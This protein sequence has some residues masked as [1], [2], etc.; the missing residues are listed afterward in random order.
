MD[1]L[2]QV[3]SNTSLT[4]PL[5][6]VTKCLSKPFWTQL[7][8]LHHQAPLPNLE[9]RPPQTGP[10]SEAHACIHFVTVSID[11]SPS[12]PLGILVSLRQHMLPDT[13]I[14]I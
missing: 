5:T 6:A 7:Q 9:A 2:I 11:Y 12:G 8:R 14:K 3:V 10:A 4:V 1:C 13:W